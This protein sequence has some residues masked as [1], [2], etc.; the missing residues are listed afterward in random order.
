MNDPD[1]EKQLEYEALEKQ[2][3]EHGEWQGDSC[4]YTDPKDGTVYEWNTEK[5]AWFPKIDDNFIAAYQANYGYENTATSCTSKEETA[6]SAVLKQPQKG[7]KRK[8]NSEPGWFEV[9]DAHNTNVY[10]SNLPLSMTDE[11]FVELMSKCGLVMK[12]PDSGQFKIKLYRNPDGSMKGDGRCCYIK[13]ESVDLALNIL[14]GYIYKDKVIHV[15]RAKFELKGAYDPSKKPRKKKGKE[16]EKMKKKI[17]KLFDWRPEKLR[18]MRGK[19]ENVVIIYNMFDP[20]EFERDPSLIM[21]YQKD[22]REECS[23]CGEVKKVVVYDRHPEGIVSVSFKEVEQAD[24]CVVLMNGRWFAGRQLRA[25]TWDGRTKY[26]IEESA[27]DRE[28]RLAQW[29]K[30]LDGEEGEPKSAS[31]NPT[32]SNTKTEKN[33]AFGTVAVENSK[34]KITS[35]GTMSKDE[36]ETESSGDSEPDLDDS[37]QNLNGKSSTANRKN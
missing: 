16:K 17:E 26:K 30:F 19:H 29:D 23:K 13:V 14:D 11:E 4:V 5:Q 15:E 20:I 21:E 36:A 6:S 22:V 35:K 33:P 31:A 9:D 7:E 3:Q 2:K 10:V 37:E 34:K 12:D 32:L 28:K 1:F 24:E 25:E 8:V 27:E 18:G